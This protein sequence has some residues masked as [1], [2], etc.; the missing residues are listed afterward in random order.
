VRATVV[1]RAAV[2]ASQSLACRGHGP[3]KRCRKFR[4]RG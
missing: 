1:F 4:M 3:Q 2:M